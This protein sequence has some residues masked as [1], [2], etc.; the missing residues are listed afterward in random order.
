MSGYPGPDQ[1]PF[2]KLESGGPILG[3]SNDRSGPLL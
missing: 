3:E 2:R 1:S